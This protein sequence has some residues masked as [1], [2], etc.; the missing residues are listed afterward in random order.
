MT[1][2][3]A[4]PPTVTVIAPAPVPTLPRKSAE[5]P[6]PEGAAGPA[7]PDSGEQSFIY[8]T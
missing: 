4:L 1:I 6:A 5:R 3:T 8:I 7:F 2:S